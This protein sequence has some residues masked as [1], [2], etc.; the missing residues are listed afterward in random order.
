MGD[1]VKINFKVYQGATFRQEFRW[2]SAL[3]GYAKITD[4][5]RSAPMQVTVEQHNIPVGWRVR[6]VG[7]AGMKEAN[8]LDY[9]TVTEA[10]QYS[11]VL[12]QVNSLGFQPY[13]SGGVVEY[14]LPVPLAGYSAR[15]QIR[16]KVAS[17]LPIYTL[18]TENSGIYIDLDRSVIGLV[19]PASVTAG[20]TFTQAVYQLELVDN[21]TGD[22]LQFAS[23]RLALDKEVTR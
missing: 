9:V 18:T 5:S 14:N 10:T 13:T 4:I 21:S 1:P 6:F 11:L 2:E 15:M 20:F 12:N 23:G 22:V 7:I 19:I 17:E 8:S 16:E 3:K